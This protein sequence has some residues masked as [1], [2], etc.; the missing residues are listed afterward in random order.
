MD[1]QIP[2]AVVL[3]IL[4]SLVSPPNLV[5]QADGRQFEV[6]GH[7]ATLRLSDSDGKTNVGWGGRVSYDVFRWIAVEGELNLFADDVFE[8]RGSTP[9]FAEYTL[10]Y[11]RRRVDGF[12]GAKVGVRRDRFGLFGKVRPGFARLFNEGIGCVGDP[13]ALMLVAPVEYETE[14]ALDFGGVVEFYPTARTVTR[15]DLGS[16]WI[17]HRSFA[18]PC[19]ACNS[20]NFAS[21]IGVGLRF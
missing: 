11:E 12:F 21:R 7:V 4:S 20:T 15:L 14:F 17:R 1:R 2:V 3:L 13:C 5:A 8:Q 10:S 18:P 6:G 9:I 19:L 16:T